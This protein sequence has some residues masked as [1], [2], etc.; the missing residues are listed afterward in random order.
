MDE[1]SVAT[2]LR[3]ILLAIVR[4]RRVVLGVYLGIVATAVVGIFLIPPQYRAATKVLLTSDRAQLSTSAERPTEI[5]RTNQV[6][7]GEIAS[8]LQLLTSRE[9]IGSVLDEM[10]VPVDEPAPKQ[11]ADSG[12]SWNPFGWLRSGYRRFHNL[13]EVESDSPRYWQVRELL[14]HLSAGRVGLSNLIEIDLDGPDP[15]WIRDFVDRLAKAYV[16]QHSKMQQVQEAEDFFT[17]QSEIL[18]KKLGD[19]EAALRELRERAGSLAGQQAEVHERLNEFTADLARTRIA[20]AEQ[21]QRVA[22]L[23]GLLANAAKRGRV[24]TPQ[25]LELEGR[26]AELVG[27]YREDS[28][29]VRD[30][31]AQIA[32]LRAAIAQYDTVTTSSEGGTGTGGDGT[33]LVG[34]RTA[35]VALRGKEA[36]LE[37]Q[38]EEYR[39]QAEMLDR[40][41]FDLARLERQVKLDEE[42]YVSYVRTAEQSRLSNAL[43]QSK[44]LRLSIVEPATVPL[45]PV[46]P[47]KGRILF[48]A[49]AGG[50]VV[51]IGAG[52]AR[53]QFDGTLKSAGDVRRF[54]KVEVLA[55][56]P[57]KV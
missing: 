38:N 39:K 41:S 50:L 25:L 55:V 16:E 19:S 36:A 46:S 32:R 23:E 6:L 7:D 13:E 40:Q 20:R 30:L 21:E 4:Q 9:L 5:V 56:I 27:R 37:K 15:M 33:S 49:L 17:Q 1:Q 31:D 52:L 22:Y 54:G 57:E 2:A 24:A 8:Q 34:A 10:G 29:R 28:E 11:P 26:R 47:K 45:E 43:E 44:I 53:D 51:G 48:F 3:E 14:T 12:R 35:L 42:A 18:Q